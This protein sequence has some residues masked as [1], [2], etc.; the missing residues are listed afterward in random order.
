MLEANPQVIEPGQKYFWPVFAYEFF[1]PD[2]S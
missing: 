2:K 1:C